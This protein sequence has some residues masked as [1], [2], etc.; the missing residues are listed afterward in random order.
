[1]AVNLHELANM[2][3]AGS[4]TKELQKAGH[5]DEDAGKSV[6]RYVVELR[7]TIYHDETYILD[8][9]SEDEAK[10]KAVDK[11]HEEFVIKSCDIDDIEVEEVE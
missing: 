6:K 8:A 4:A 5:W 1:M 10:K 3:G 7:A 11:M 2:P 9:R